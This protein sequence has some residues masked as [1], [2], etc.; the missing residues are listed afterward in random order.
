MDCPK[1]L[2][3][4]RPTLPPLEELVPLLQEIWA[5]RQLTNHGPLHQRFEAGLAR[6]LDVP[7]VTLVTNATLGL[8]VALRQLQTSGEVITT[9]FS[10]VA[11]AHSVLWQGMTPVFAD[12]DPVTL[13][14]DPRQ[15]ERHITPRTSAI[16]AVHCYGR[17]CDVEAIATIA[18]R[19]NLKVLYDA[20]HA[21]AVRHNG[22][23][24]LNY[25][26]LSVISFHATKVFNTFEGG[27]IIS[28]DYEAKQSL[29]Q[30]CNCGIVDETTV[31]STGLNAKMSE[32]NA[33]IGLLQLRHVDDAIHKRQEIDSRY[34]SLLTGIPGIRCASEPPDPAAHNF[35]A[36]P[37]FVGPEYSLSRD[38]LYLKLRDR[39]IHARRYFFPLISDLPMY[40]S[41]E[42]ASP[43]ALPVASSI[44]AQVLCL[45]MFPE[46]LAD[47]QES[48]AALIRDQ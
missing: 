38:E 2:Y 1:P 31:A 30:L 21:F 7:Y 29:D 22:R 39:G 37:I 43:A 26:D 45:P 8:M 24:V 17:P 4:T 44:A 20:A 34:R 46:L 35:Y 18:N 25:G 33:A 13:N 12:I 42:S 5:S 16:L 19:H 40:R 9:P 41:L 11:T 3:V 28:H 14:L 6:Y 32:F 10:F 36:F 27:A 23:N 15:I 48:I 47:E